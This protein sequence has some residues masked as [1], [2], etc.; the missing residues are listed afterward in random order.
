MQ[1]A[2][3]GGGGGGGVSGAERGGSIYL[4]W[5]VSGVLGERGANVRV[6]VPMSAVESDV[7]YTAIRCGSAVDAAVCARVGCVCRPEPRR[8]PTALGSQARARELAAL[9]CRSCRTCKHDEKRVRRQ[10]CSRM[11][12]PRRATSAHA[13]C[14]YVNT[15]R[16]RQPT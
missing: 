1:G 3:R 9:G 2:M 15:S 4:E 11:A 14:P 5:C 6:D 8:A 7:T 10:W 12:A 13:T 16:A